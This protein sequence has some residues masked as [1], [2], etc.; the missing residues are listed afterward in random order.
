MRLRRYLL[1]LSTG[2]LCA[3]ATLP[4]H[5][6]RRP[7]G[8]LREEPGN[9]VMFRWP[10]GLVEQ[11]LLAYLA[12]SLLPIKP[13]V[14][15]PTLDERLKCAPFVRAQGRVGLDLTTLDAAAADTLR[16]AAQSAGSGGQLT[17]QRYISVGE[18]LFQERRAP[19]PKLADLYRK[20]R[21]PG[22]PAWWHVDV[23]STISRG[24][25]RI[26]FDV[27]NTLET[28]LTALETGRPLCHPADTYYVAEQFNAD[29][30]LMDT[31]ISGKRAD[32]D[33]DFL[34]YDPAGDLVANSP[35][36]RFHS[37]SSC[38]RCH[39]YAARLT[40]FREFPDTPP[41]TQTLK[42]RVMVDLAAADVPLIKAFTEAGARPEDV[43]GT[44]G[45][46]AALRLRDMRKD[47]A[48]PAW[49]LP[50]WERLLK[51][52]PAAGR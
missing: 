47:P 2:V 35:E 31:H 3:M 48:A 38:F 7:P 23:M 30:S 12:S 51:A 37:P 50:L 8:N 6:A 9:T 41:P 24:R 32:G 49:V 15:R 52:V 43:H 44:Y 46:L 39:R 4:V 10:G 19:G 33:W 25:R 17:Y 16:A 13:S 5:A 18:K 29:D 45:G 1:F 42:P 21:F 40:P 11:E 20:L 36:L 34:Q 14:V 22:D 28:S 27:R 26:W